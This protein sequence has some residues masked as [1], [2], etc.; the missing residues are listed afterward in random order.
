MDLS[1]LLVSAPNTD[2]S[3]NNSVSNTS[4]VTFGPASGPA[5]GD[6]ANVYVR[7][8]GDM[9]GRPT[10]IP[11]EARIPR[12]TSAPA[13][14]RMNGGSSVEI[15]AGPSAQRPGTSSVV[16][17]GESSVEIDA[18]PPVQRPGTSH[19]LRP[20]ANATDPQMTVR[21]SWRQRVGMS[22]P[23]PLCVELRVLGDEASRPDVLKMRRLFWRRCLPI[24]KITRR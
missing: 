4:A 2:G 1:G 17:D 5:S 15:D 16:D 3:S 6:E 10:A 8:S 21:R 23:D 20:D 7:S 24:Q 14:A 9:S 18:G 13:V 19:I 22:N 12:P 11:E